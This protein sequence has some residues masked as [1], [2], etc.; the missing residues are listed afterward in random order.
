MQMGRTA[1][2]GLRRAMRRPAP[3]TRAAA[4][5]REP[6]AT[7]LQAAVSSERSKISS[8]AA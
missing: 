4:G 3:R 1:P 2:L 6:Q 5:E 7:M 8:W